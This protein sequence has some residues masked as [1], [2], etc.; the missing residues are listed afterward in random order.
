MALFVVTW[1]TLLRSRESVG[2]TAVMAANPTA[3]MQSANF[4][5]GS[6]APII[7]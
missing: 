5:S 3:G 1:R 4:A 7:P 6:L 2:E